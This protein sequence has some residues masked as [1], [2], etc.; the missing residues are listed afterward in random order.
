[1]GIVNQTNVSMQDINNIINL[2]THDPTEFMLNINHFVYAGWFFFILLCIIGFLLF[3]KAQ[4]KQDQPLINIMYVSTALTLVSFLM[5]AWFV[6]RDGI[7]IG[8]ITDFQLWIFPLIA[9]LTA[10][11]VKFS[12]N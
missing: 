7:F 5:R 9:I 3:R 2:T 6:Y 1:M 8:A 10:T 12:S 11:M 4:E